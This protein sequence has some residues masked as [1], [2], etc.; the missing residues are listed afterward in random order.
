[1]SNGRRTMS[2]VAVRLF[3]IILIAA[4]LTSCHGK[5][6][7]GR[8]AKTLNISTERELS[9]RRSTGASTESLVALSPT[10]LKDTVREFKIKDL[11]KARA[12]YEHLLL[13]SEKGTIPEGATE[14]AIQRLEQLKGLVANRRFT[15]A[16]VPV[17]NNQRLA[18]TAGIGTGAAS[19]IPLG[20]SEVGGRTRAIA[21]NPANAQEVWIGSVAGGIWH[22]TDGGNSFN[23]S[24]DFMKN[25]VISSLTF[26]RSQSG[27]PTHPKVLYAGTGEGFLNNDAFRGM[28]IF[29]SDDGLTWTQIPATN[30]INFRYVNRL[31]LS[32]D[33]KVLFAATSSGVFVSSDAAH[34]IWSSAPTLSGEITDIVCHPSNSNLVLASGGQNTGQVFYSENGGLSWKT[35]G[36]WSA[37]NGPTGRIEITYALANPSI[38][39][40]SVDSNSGQVWRSTDSGQSFSPM[41]SVTSQG[42][43]AFYLGDQGWYDNAIWAGDPKDPN[44]L[45]VG[46]VDLWRSTDGGAT[47]GPISNW[48]DASNVLHSDQHIIVSPPVPG[49]SAVFV[50]NDGG[51]YKTDDVRAAGSDKANTSG[52]IKIG[53]NYAVTQFYGAAWSPKSGMLIGGA[54]DNGTLRLWGGGK[55]ADWSELFGGDGGDCAADSQDGSYAYGEYVFLDIFR[56]SD[57]GKTAEEISGEY[58]N[59]QNK[60]FEWKNAPYRIED[61]YDSVVTNPKNPKA[62]FIAP[63]IVDP[64]HPNTILAGGSSLWRTDTAMAQNTA[65]SGPSWRPIKPPAS[66]WISAVTLGRD[67]KTIWIGHNNGEIYITSNGNDGHPT[68]RKISPSPQIFPARIVTK[69]VIDPT[70]SNTVYVT[71]GG[72]SDS[73][74]MDNVWRTTNGGKGWLNLS[75]SLPSSPAYA[76]TIHPQNRNYVYVGTE[77]GLFASEDMGAHWSP[78][79]V[80][81]TNEGPT[82]AA[83][84]DFVWMNTTLVAVTHGRGMFKTDLALAKPGR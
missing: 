28:G 16:G 68:W 64:N 27:S 45:V 10:E 6:D 79:T 39:Y 37:R 75:K 17:S 63:F 80:A 71:F 82:N 59:D 38:V 13:Q 60:E 72:Y 73:G 62:L 77:N 53:H 24:D 21:F 41:D 54:Q 12:N 42:V 29:R 11:P 43:L 50:G 3:G 14:R 69:I 84:M 26:D 19:W 51:L 22:S 83:V 56:S 4:F 40:A 8:V 66:D 44:L 49:S 55:P 35:S 23:A 32:A 58:W 2:K 34:A 7:D 9:L 25:L 67:S 20:P 18:R 78:T 74:Q 57:G 1:M 76:I 15:V 47:L 36:P 33:G 81:P 65:T 61:A 5:I 46:G 70:D 31:A 30:N 48:Q 52:W